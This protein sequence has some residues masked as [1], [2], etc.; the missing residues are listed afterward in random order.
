M[1]QLGTRIP[2]TTHNFD[3]KNLKTLQLKNKLKDIMD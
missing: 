2:P 1:L 3:M